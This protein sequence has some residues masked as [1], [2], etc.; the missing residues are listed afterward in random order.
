MSYFDNV[1][2]IND[3]ED[4]IVYVGLTKTNVFPNKKHF[5]ST[6]VLQNEQY[7]P[8]LVSYRLFQNV[9]HAWIIDEMNNFYHGFKEY[10]T[11]RKIFYLTKTDLIGLG[12]IR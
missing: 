12:F 5:L 8:D 9:N 4:N 11:G 1:N 2:F 3:Q 10:E 7:R 6:Y